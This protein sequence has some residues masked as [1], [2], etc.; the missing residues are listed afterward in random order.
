M[1]WIIR[2]AI[3]Q[4]NSKYIAF[5]L[6]IIWISF[7]LYL[8]DYHLYRVTQAGTYTLAVLGLCLLIGT[9]GQISVGHSAFFALGA[10]MTAISVLKFGISIYVSIWVGALSGLLLGFL[11]GWPALR[12]SSINL[13]LATWALAVVT[14][15]IL[16]LS[17]FESWTGGSS[18]LY[19]DEINVPF[20]LNISNDEWW[21]IVTLLYIIVVLW[22]SYNLRSGRIRRALL[23]VRDNPIAAETMGIRTNF[24]KTIIFGLSAAIVSM[25]G[26]LTTALTDFVSPQKYDLYFAMI[27]IFGAFISG[28]NG[29]IT[30]FLGGFLIEFLPDIA[31]AVSDNLAS[32]QIFH[33]IL[34][35]LL[36][37]MLP[38]GLRGLFLRIEKALN[39]FSRK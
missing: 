6:I 36:V 38:E 13:L 37:Y 14:P 39:I 4:K 26:G 8:Q 25:A 11:F 18:G 27:L 29:I 10:Y 28:I 21:H 35:L 33:G 2:N 34:L 23:A 9:T 16:N 12:L 31:F 1:K 17:Y 5:F 30:A 15:K 7:P 20:N 24:Y 3:A 32:P 19:I 22:I